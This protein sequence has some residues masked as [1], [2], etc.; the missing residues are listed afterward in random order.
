MQT[1]ATTASNYTIGSYRH[2]YTLPSY[3]RQ[4]ELAIQG[5]NMVDFIYSPLA[6]A[7]RLPSYSMPRGNSI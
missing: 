4:M 5:E 6:I 2:H 7:S 1:A 3:V